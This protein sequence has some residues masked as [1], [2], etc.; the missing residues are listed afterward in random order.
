MRNFDL[1]TL[2]SFITVSETGGMTAAANKLHM[3][4]STI[5]MQIKRLEESVG[6]PLLDRNSGRGIR[7]TAEGDQ[8]LGYARSMLDLNDEIW[9]R[10]TA[11]KYEGSICLGVPGDVIRPHIP[12][13]LKQ[14]NRDF[15][16]VQVRL[17]TAG[18][19]DLATEIE[20][21]QQDLILTTEVYDKDKKLPDNGELLAVQPLLWTG[22]V[23]GHAWMA[24]PLPVAMVRGCA[25]R[26]SMIDALEQANIP[27]LDAVDTDSEDSTSV[28]VAADFAVRPELPTFS[29]P[30][31]EEID[32]R[33]ELPTLPRCSINMYLADG[34]NKV[35]AEELAIYIRGAFGG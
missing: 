14:F 15:P 34:P 7:P 30:G 20:H 23:N 21:G 19:I 18:S 24:R 9:G 22:A 31:I 32:H 4:Q 12:N 33:G 17:K 11:P 26:R 16:R 35:L 3:T 28:A 10:L 8:L 25:F 29:D 1:G 27:W 5:S 2:R 6:L 13:V